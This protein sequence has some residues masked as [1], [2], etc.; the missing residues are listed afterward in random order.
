MICVKLNIFILGLLY[1]NT[2]G[3]FQEQKKNN[4]SSGIVE[5][6]LKKKIFKQYLEEAHRLA[7]SYGYNMGK[8]NFFIFKILTTK[9]STF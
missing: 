7:S 4:D 5:G 6:K 8:V 2:F 9:F 1:K 3:F